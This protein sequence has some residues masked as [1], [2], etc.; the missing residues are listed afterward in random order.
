[1]EE[2]GDLLLGAGRFSEQFPLLNIDSLPLVVSKLE[3]LVSWSCLR[4]SGFSNVVET[5]MG[6]VLSALR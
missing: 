6:E 2:E 4:P 3:I 5:L 1:M